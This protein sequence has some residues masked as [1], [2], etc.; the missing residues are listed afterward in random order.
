MITRLSFSGG[1]RVLQFGHGC[2]AVEMDAV[3]EAWV[4]VPVPL[5]FGHG[6]GAVEISS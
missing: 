5:Q 3:T 1:T 6:C 4:T 2:G